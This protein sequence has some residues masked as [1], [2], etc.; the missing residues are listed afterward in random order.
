MRLEQHIGDGAGNNHEHDVEH[1]VAQGI[2]AKKGDGN[3]GRNDEQL[4][5]IKDARTDAHQQVTYEQHADIGEDHADNEG[6]GYVRIFFHEL[7]AWREALRHEAAGK[8]SGRGTAGDAERKQGHQRTAHAGVIGAFRHEY[9]FDGALS[10]TVRIF[11]PAFGLIV[12]DQRGHAAAGARQRANECADGRG[13]SQQTQMTQN[14][15]ESALQGVG[16]AS[17]AYNVGLV[18]FQHDEHL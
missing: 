18:A 15:D 9:A 13:H 16:L 12:G 6:V 1:A 5:H 14:S 17:H 11:V 3:D 4:G 10:V 8:H 2:G 7:G